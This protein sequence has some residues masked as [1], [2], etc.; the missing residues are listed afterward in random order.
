VRRRREASL[1][2][3]RSVAV[4]EPEAKALDV[5]QQHE[6]LRAPACRC[7]CVR[8]CMCVRACVRACVRVCIPRQEGLHMWKSDERHCATTHDLCL[9]CLA[10]KPPRECEACVALAP[11]VAAR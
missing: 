6:V 1:R 5:A 8:A 3:P 2:L 10:L 4:V 7:A 11:L 9:R